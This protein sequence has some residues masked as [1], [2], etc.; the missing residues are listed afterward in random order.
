MVEQ[1]LDYRAL[2]DDADER[3]AVRES[4]ATGLHAAFWFGLA[5]AIVGFVVAISIDESKLRTDAPEEE[6]AEI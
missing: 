3:R 4:F 5:V 1:N 6:A 2:S